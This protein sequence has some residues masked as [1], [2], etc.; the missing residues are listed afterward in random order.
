MLPRRIELCF[1]LVALCSLPLIARAES[2]SAGPVAANEPTEIQHPQD[3]W[4]I[5]GPARDQP[6][7]IHMEIRINYV[8]TAWRN[9]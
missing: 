3:F 5:S 7:E 2:A 1:F 6:H 4:A 8:D 9:F